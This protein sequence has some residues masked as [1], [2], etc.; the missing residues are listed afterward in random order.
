MEIREDGLSFERNDKRIDV[1]LAYVGAD[2]D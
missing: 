1:G 2:Q